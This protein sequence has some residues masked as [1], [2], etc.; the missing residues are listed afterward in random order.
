MSRAQRNV[1]LFGSEA[2]EPEVGNATDDKISRKISK[3][4]EDEDM[5]QDQAVAVAHDMARRGDL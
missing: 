3:L 2:N 4:V 1:R 5:P